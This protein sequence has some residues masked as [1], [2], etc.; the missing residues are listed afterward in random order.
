MTYNPFATNSF[1]VV[2]S[3][4]Q[5]AL[6][7]VSQNMSTFG[8]VSSDIEGR[9]ITGAV[10]S[11]AGWGDM[12][13]EYFNNYALNAMQTFN[14]TA[15]IEPSGTGD[16]RVIGYGL[17]LRDGSKIHWFG[18]RDLGTT[19][20][21]MGL[22]GYSTDSFG[23]VWDDG[24]GTPTNAHAIRGFRI[25]Q[26]ATTRYF[27]YSFSSGGYGPWIS[28]ATRTKTHI[29]IPFQF[30]WFGYFGSAGGNVKLRYL[31]VTS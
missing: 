27:E 21:N 11:T 24:A 28:W 12:R 13:G 31:R 5:S 9:I 17:Y 22:L 15:T 18:T 6:L 23:G 2:G 8:S 19:G 30:G 16:G 7:P 1:S 25:R 4:A 26:D 29:L 14:I 20:G 10:N 3:P